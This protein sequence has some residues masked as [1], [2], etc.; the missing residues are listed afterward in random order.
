[1][2]EYRKRLT[3]GDETKKLSYSHIHLTTV[4]AGC[5]ELAGGYVEMCAATIREVG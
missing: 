2:N 4:S 1:M 5:H 3:V